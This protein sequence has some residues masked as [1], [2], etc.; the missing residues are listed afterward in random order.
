M[1]DDMVD[2]LVSLVTSNLLYDS[3]VCLKQSQ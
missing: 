3:I 1:T 2:E